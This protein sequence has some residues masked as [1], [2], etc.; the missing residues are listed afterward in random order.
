MRRRLQVGARGSASH[1]AGGP[2]SNLLRGRSVAPFSYVHGQEAQL[3]G[4]EAK[5]V[6]GVFELRLGDVGF[7]HVDERLA[8]LVGEIAQKAVRVVGLG[9]S[10]M[11]MWTSYV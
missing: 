2:R 11:G 6:A 8:D 5:P 4:E 1:A 7:G 10:G 3:R 9:E